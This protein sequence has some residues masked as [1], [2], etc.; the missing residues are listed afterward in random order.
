M[1]KKMKLPGTRR[2]L[3]FEGET[4]ELILII[5]AVCVIGAGLVLVYGGGR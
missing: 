1:S 3:I 2:T 4:W 5:V